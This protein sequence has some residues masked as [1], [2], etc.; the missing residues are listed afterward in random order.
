MANRHRTDATTIPDYRAF[1]ICR[2]RDT[3]RN[4][5]WAEYRAGLIEEMKT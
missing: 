2:F 4:R 5:R 1:G 3:L